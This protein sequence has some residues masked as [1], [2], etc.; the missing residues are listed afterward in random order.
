MYRTQLL[1]KGFSYKD[2]EPETIFD[3]HL[4]IVI[5]EMIKRE[6]T[7]EIS[8][9]I[10]DV[11]KHARSEEHAAE[12]V[13]GLKELYLIG[14]REQEEQRK[15]LEHEK[16]VRLMEEGIMISSVTKEEAVGRMVKVDRYSGKRIE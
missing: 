15:K 7:I 6:S 13:R 11:Y 2:W 5:L 9:Q 1:L 8:R 14:F 4:E 12:L 10:L 16:F 3:V